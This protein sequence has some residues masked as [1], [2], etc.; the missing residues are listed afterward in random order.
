MFEI[1]KN[2]CPGKRTEIACTRSNQQ[3]QQENK[4]C[5]AF[6]DSFM[7][8]KMISF[9]EKSTIVYHMSIFFLRFPCVAG[10]RNLSCENS[11]HAI[12]LIN[13]KIILNIQMLFNIEINICLT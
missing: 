11:I 3:Q 13:W 8:L 6:I 9:T 7:F 1:F 4:I 12:L 2:I 10:D 5:S